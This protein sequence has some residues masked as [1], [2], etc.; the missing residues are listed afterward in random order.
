MKGLTYIV[1]S[2]TRLGLPQFDVLGGKSLDLASEIDDAG[3]G[4]T[5][6]HVDSNVVLLV[7]GHFGWRWS[8]SASIEG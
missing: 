4:R 1:G 8:A 3:S 6:A 2:L 7:P 5:S